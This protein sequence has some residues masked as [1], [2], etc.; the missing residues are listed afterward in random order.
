M[1]VS[2]WGKILCGLVI[3]ATAVGCNMPRV[4]VAEHQTRHESLL[5]SLRRL[6]SDLEATQREKEGLEAELNA[7]AVELKKA[8]GSVAPSVSETAATD[9][10]ATFVKEI[11]DRLAEQEK[12]LLELQSQ[13][14]ALQASLGNFQAKAIARLT[15]IGGKLDV[16]PKTGVATKADLRGAR[17]GEG[18]FA[19][20]G[21]L[22][23]LKEVLLTG[24][25]VN[26]ESMRVLATLPGLEV[27]DATRSA[28]GDPG[29]AYFETHKKL[30]K[31]V[32]F[33]CDVT[34]AGFD[35]LAKMPVLAEIDC[36]QT[37]IS[38][39]GLEK[40]RGKKTITHLDFSDCNQISSKGLEVVGT[41]EGLKLIRVWGPNIKDDGLQHLKNLKQLRLVGLNDTAVTSAG[42]EVFKD[43]KELRE[44]H[45]ARCTQVRDDGVAFLAACTKMQRLYLRDTGISGAALQHLVNM[46]DLRSL[47]LSECASPGPDDASLA[48]LSGLTNL[49]ELVLWR[50][51]VTD[52]GIQHL[53]PLKKMKKLNLD[54]T[55]IK[56]GAMDIVAGFSDLEWLHIGSNFPISDDGLKKLFKNSKLKYINVTFDSFSDEVLE[57][58]KMALPEC[59]VD[60]P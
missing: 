57:E 19:L 52:A 14:N 58:L 42:L 46:K 5:K 21:Y 56:D 18:D 31:I 50:T 36:G 59:Q 47:D 3:S 60:G 51:T 38:D 39:A 10:P 12:R 20:V 53:A 4:G 15:E 9:V 32:L 29:L 6:Q 24:P 33:R 28:V 40:L 2:V 17:W 26:N 41:F 27:L 23:G 35:S 55:K 54:K 45:L 8:G 48:H 11:Q 22:P 7:M 30:R 44:L 13:N 25:D 37:R 1:R 34:D 43:K 49:E 16:D